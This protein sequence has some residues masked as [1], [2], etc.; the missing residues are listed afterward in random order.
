MENEEEVKEKEVVDGEAE[1]EAGEAESEVKSAVEG[2]AGEAG[3]EKRMQYGAVDDSLA[4]KGVGN[5][6]EEK[7]NKSKEKKVSTSTNV[8]NETRDRKERKRGT[9]G[10]GDKKKTNGRHPLTSLEM[11]VIQRGQLA[12]VLRSRA[13][14]GTMTAEVCFYVFCCCFFFL[15]FIA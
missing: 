12:R 1:R 13:G 2:E 15:L 14:T 8:S 3:D 11:E 10:G 9:R 7:N 5:E 6:G 4:A